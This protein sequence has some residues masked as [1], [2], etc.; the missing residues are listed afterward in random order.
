MDGIDGRD[1]D[2]D[3]GESEFD[4]RVREVR[5]ALAAM[6]APA[7][8]SSR[9]VIIA[10]RDDIKAKARTHGIEAVWKTYAAL[11]HAVTLGTFRDYVYNGEK[12]RRAKGAEAETQRKRSARIRKATTAPFS[13]PDD[14]TES[15]ANGRPVRARPNV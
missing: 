5:E 4:Q 7:P 8:A 13:L 10:T 3:P 2:V 11:G 1:G 12:S 14:A 6:P 9:Q 15:T